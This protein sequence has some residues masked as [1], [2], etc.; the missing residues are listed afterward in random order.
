SFCLLL[1]ACSGLKTQPTGG[2]TQPGSASLTAVAVTPGSTSIAVSATASLHATGTFSDGSTQDLTSTV[3]WSS[4]D[5]SVASVT[6][7]GVA[8]GAATV[9]A[10][11]GSIMQSTTVTVTAPSISSISVTPEDLTLAIGITQQF[12]ATA[13]YSDGSS[14]DLVTGVTWSSST[15]SVATIDGN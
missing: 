6:A 11:L 4:S 1:A 2:G 3:Q 12:T 5:P 13:I 9:T 14:Q 10:N 7:A 15:T 8:A